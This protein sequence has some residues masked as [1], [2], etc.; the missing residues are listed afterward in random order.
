MSDE[1]SHPRRRQAADIVDWSDRAIVAIRATDTDQ[2]HRVV[3]EVLG[4]DRLTPLLRHWTDTIVRFAEHDETGGVHAPAPPLTGDNRELWMHAVAELFSATAAGD[5]TAAQRIC[6]GIAAWSDA[7]Q[8]ALAETFARVVSSAISPFAVPSH[9][10]VLSQW[11]STG[12]RGRYDEKLVRDMAL[13][14][15]RMWLDDGTPGATAAGALLTTT[16]RLQEAVTLLARTLGSRLAPGAQVVTRV[17]G[18]DAA[19]HSDDLDAATE[20]PSTVLDPRR[21][22]LLYAGRAV[23]DM[24]NGEPDRVAADLESIGDDREML[25][26]V[27]LSLAYMFRTTILRMAPDMGGPA[28]R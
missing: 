5:E 24:A 4:A 23:R 15:T 8:E 14:V 12:A 10:V 19:D 9:Y 16:E 25:G 11:L 2:L 7:D 1:G 18:V 6:S 21:R 27:V 22:A 20:D 26:I 3:T 17:I 28:A 13:V